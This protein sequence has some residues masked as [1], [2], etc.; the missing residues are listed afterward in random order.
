MYYVSYL[1]HQDLTEFGFEAGKLYYCYSTFIT[2][3]TYD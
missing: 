3:G 1:R 2:R